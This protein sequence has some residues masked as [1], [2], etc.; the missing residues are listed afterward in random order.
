MA[1]AKIKNIKARQILDS[2]GNPTVE[3]DVETDSGFIGR[4]A[5][6]SGASTGSRE[7]LEIRDNN[8]RIYCG[9]SVLKAVDN[10]NNSLS[11]K[12]K[13]EYIEEQ[14]KIDKVMRQI[15]GTQDKSKLGANAIL[16]VSL[17][18]AKAAALDKRVE[19][20]EYFEELL[21]IGDCSNADYG[22]RRSKQ[23]LYH[24]DRSGKF[25][26]PVPMMNILNGGVHADNQI[27]IQ[28]FMIIPVSAKSFSHALQM[29]TEVFHALKNILKTKN[30]STNVG[31]EGGFAPN[32]KSN[33]TAIEMLILAIEKAGY[34]IWADICIALDAAASEFYDARTEKYLF[35]NSV[36]DYEDMVNYWE[37]LVSKYPIVSIEDG[38]AEDD[39]DGWAEL[40]RRIGSE[41]QLVGDDLFV[42]NYNSL[43]YDSR[44]GS[45][46][47]QI[48]N[49]ILIKP[50]QVGTVTETL[51]TI[52]LAKE[53]GYTTVI[54]HRSGET[55]DV[56]IADLAVG[57][58][59]GQIKTGSLSRSDRVA[60][61]NQLL[62]I[63]EK[64]GSNA[65]YKG[66]PGINK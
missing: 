43:R 54:S 58:N 35:N 62:R 48:A 8:S 63:E 45:N 4:A 13:G 61:Y 46:K 42:T 60:K 7:A 11:L 27:D 64:L 10:V 66:Y 15:D 18:V 5:A 22:W 28:E 59:A 65:I 19:L 21:H 14:D 36:L 33:E 37:W 55:E 1:S 30:L 41:V 32:I 29:G 39:Y 56:T 44:Y 17:A 53:L 23:E 6:P 38:L 20:Y 31:D 9:K 2:R 51:S 49:S 12:L 24:K 34:K 57:C 52:E 26:L 16:P 47:S 50:N 3:V 40:T 25:T